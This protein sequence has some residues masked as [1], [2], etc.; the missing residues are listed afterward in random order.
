MFGFCAIWLTKSL[1]CPLL[2]FQWNL[3][4]QLKQ[5]TWANLIGTRLG[6]NEEKADSARLPWWESWTRARMQASNMDNGVTVERHTLKTFKVACHSLLASGW[7]LLL[8][9]TQIKFLTWLNT[10][11][12]FPP[13]P[14]CHQPFRTTVKWSSQKVMRTFGSVL[15]WVYTPVDYWSFAITEKGSRYQFDSGDDFIMDG[16]FPKY[17][18][19]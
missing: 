10:L 14:R 5:V 15:S 4:V 9:S 3:L 6:M 18:L 13:P 2:S 7:V 1:G 8:M 19:S 16:F 11:W 12:L 17:A